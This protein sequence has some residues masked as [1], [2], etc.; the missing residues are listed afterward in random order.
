MEQ[1]LV[2]P[3]LRT[4]SCSLLTAQPPLCFGKGLEAFDG[5]VPAVAGIGILCNKSQCRHKARDKVSP[6]LSQS[7]VG[8]RCEG[9]QCQTLSQVAAEVSVLLGH[10]PPPT[11]FCG[12]L[13]APAM[14]VT[15]LS[16]SSY[17]G[18]R[19]GCPSAIPGQRNRA[20]P[21]QRPEL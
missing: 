13:W 11:A 5:P 2:L 6:G 7:P 12:T 16:P 17:A 9:S 10:F 3:E 15:R 8:R 4:S 14:G 19:V 18:T 21:A 1:R 20:S